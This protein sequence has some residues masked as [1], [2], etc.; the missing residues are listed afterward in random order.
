VASRNF[1]FIR[2]RLATTSAAYSLSDGERDRSS[3]LFKSNV[4]RIKHFE[5]F[6]YGHFWVVLIFGQFSQAYAFFLNTP[7]TLS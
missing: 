1:N 4:K 3:L 5:P 2:R 6:K 7:A